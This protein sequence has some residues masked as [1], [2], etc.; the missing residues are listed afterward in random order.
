[1][2]TNRRQFL[3]TTALASS[4]LLYGNSLA[5]AQEKKKFRACIIGDTPLGDVDYH[6]G[7]GHQLDR[8]FLGRDD[9]TIV[10]VADPNEESRERCMEITEAEKGY[11]DYRK[12]LDKVKPDLVAIGT[13]RSILHHERAMAALESGAHVFI[14]KPLCVS[15]KEADEIVN[16]AKKKS[17]KI[18]VAHQMRPAPAMLHLTKLIDDGLIGELIEM[19]GRSK[20]D[21]RAGGEDLVILGTHIFDLMQWF[22]EGE[23]VSCFAQVLQN[24][25]PIQPGDVRET[26]SEVGPAAGDQVDAAFL[27]DKGVTGYFS[28]KKTAEGN[29]GR[30]G[31]D[32]YGTKG[33][34]SIRM[35]QNP[36]IYVLQHASWQP[37]GEANWI[38]LP[39][40][41]ATDGP[42]GGRALT[43]N[44]RA[45]V[46]DLIYAI[47]KN[48]EPMVGARQAR[49]AVEMMAAAYTS[50]I[51]GK[52]VAF[53][54]K[55]RQHPLHLFK[56]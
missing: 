22:T 44:N 5:F 1:M 31:L 36:E 55:E 2:S 10:A 37:K 47:G 14:E 42:N 34:A 35:N 30:W 53:P 19:R 39:D 15:P 40:N 4:A 11:D 16:L 28:S 41:P 6:K 51:Q 38:P 50:Q 49:V 21:I 26:E 9:T 18:A 52:R 43:A 20:E 56:G 17:L 7:Y 48:E 8:A 45:I 27:F 33:V 13:N 24:G 23:P 32:L 46:D 54:L 29:G 3:E 12:M 25:K